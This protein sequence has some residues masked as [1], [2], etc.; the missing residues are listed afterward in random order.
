M[1]AQKIVAYQLFFKNRQEPPIMLSIEGGKRLIKH[2]SSDDRII[3]FVPIKD[4]LIATNSID[5]VIPIKR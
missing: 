2:L 3:R 4:R 1:T 5:Q